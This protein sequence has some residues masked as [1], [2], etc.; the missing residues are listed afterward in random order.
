MTIDQMRSYICN[1][2]KYKDSSK[3]KARVMR[4][5][6]PQVYA[7]FK[8]FQKV[9]YKKLERELKQQ[10]KEN[11]KYHQINMFEYE[12]SGGHAY[13]CND[14]PNKCKEWYQWEKEMKDGTN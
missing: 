12:E 8:Q 6:D 10:E 11:A 7:I 2:P 1:H 3:W 9:D 14:C 13:N 4:M 5:P